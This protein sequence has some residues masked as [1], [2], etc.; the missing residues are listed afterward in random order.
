[1]TTT[2][3]K[4]EKKTIDEKIDN[5]VGKLKI[6]N[7]EYILHFLPKSL[8]HLTSMKKFKY[9]GTKINKNTKMK[10]KETIIINPDYLIHIIHKLMMFHYRHHKF[11]KTF[12]L[13]SSVLRQEIGTHYNYYLQYLIEEGILE[14]RYNYY[15]SVSCN[16]YRLKKN[17]YYDNMVIR[18]K[19]KQ[20]TLLKKWIKRKLGDILNNNTT[21]KHINDDVMRKLIK[22]LY[23]VELDYDG[24]MQLL[25]NMYNN[26]KLDSKSTMGNQRK[27]IKNMI[28]L[29]NIHE[30]QI[31]YKQ[32]DYGR[33][34]TNYTNIKK[35]FRNGYIKIDGE[36][37]AEL[38]IDN[39]Q[40]LFLALLMREHK[41]YEND[42]YK[43]AY[44]KFYDLVTKGDFY[45]YMLNNLGIDDKDVCKEI[46]FSVLF[47]KNNLIYG[48][49][50]EA[51]RV[52]KSLFPGVFS[53]IVGFKRTDSEDEE[54]KKNNY[55]ILSHNLQNRESTIIFNRICYTIQRN[56]PHIKIFTVHDSIYFAKK[57]KKEVSEIFY[58]N[59]DALLT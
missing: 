54:V 1:M 15:N 42:Q 37:V 11:Q 20:K 30:N 47:G 5:F 55:K 25:E 49:Y 58:N 41:A 18:Y 24:S 29:V 57:Y 45:E 28:S 39:S 2:K 36:K 32:D 31:Y 53:W 40:P 44:Y 43:D 16:G 51:N 21:F 52:F 48:D 8:E 27:Y 59:I 6:E 23:Y 38:D 50:K 22:D 7:K 34:H 3:G 13:S 26:N 46:V 56:F 19:N 12:A 17:S 9:T 33:F 10:E 4:D 35:I 14:K